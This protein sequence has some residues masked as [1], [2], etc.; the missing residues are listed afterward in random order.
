MREDVGHAGARVGQRAQV[1]GVLNTPT[2]CG[3]SAQGYGWVRQEERGE[4]ATRD[5][6]D[7]GLIDQRLGPSGRHDGGVEA[8]QTADL[9]GV[10]QGDRHL[11]AVIEGA[12]QAHDA[13]REDEHGLDR[14]AGLP[15]GIASVENVA[16]TDRRKRGEAILGDLAE[17]GNAA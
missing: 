13:R 12:I 7:D 11:L 10:E 14:V 2:G 9:A 5:A 17:E 8:G 3:E 6:I 4:G 1:V 15:E 16:A